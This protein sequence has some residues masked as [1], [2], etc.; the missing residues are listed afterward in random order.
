MPDDSLYAQFVEPAEAIAQRMTEAGFDDEGTVRC[1]A[2]I[3]ERGADTY[4]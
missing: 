1:L 2:R 4:D 3:V